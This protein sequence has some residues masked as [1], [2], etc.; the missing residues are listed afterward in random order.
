MNKFI[1]AGLTSLV[2][3]SAIVYTHTHLENRNFKAAIELPISIATITGATYFCIKDRQR[4]RE[5]SVYHHQLLTQMDRRSTKE[6]Y[7]NTTPVKK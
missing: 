2:G 3:I 4:S 6:N 5:V 1:K 7:F